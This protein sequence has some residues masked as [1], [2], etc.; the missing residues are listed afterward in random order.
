[1]AP[2]ASAAE[3]GESRAYAS[4]H[5]AAFLKESPKQ[6]KKQPVRQRKKVVLL[7][8]PAQRAGMGETVPRALFGAGVECSAGRESPGRWSGRG[9][10]QQAS[11]EPRDSGHAKRRI[12]W[13]G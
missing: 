6:Q 4:A 11:S 7:C 10:D 9:S 12:W 2:E 3:S 1:M 8:P 5:C 13:I